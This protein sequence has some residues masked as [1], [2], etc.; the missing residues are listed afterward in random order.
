MNTRNNWLIYSTLRIVF[1]AVP[2][3]V[4]FWI[5]WSVWLAALTAALISLAL[6]LLFLSK[7][8][9]AASES[10]YDW[11]QRTR[12]ADD[13][14]EDEVIDALDEQPQTDTTG[15]ITAA[16]ASEQE[17]SVDRVV[18]GGGAM[19]LA[20]AWQLASRGQHVLLLER[21]APGHAEGASHGETRNMNNAYAE[22][23]FLDLYDEA[24]GLFREL[25]SASN[26]QLL[27]L[28]GLV[29]HGDPVKV[30]ATHEALIA[31]N[32]DTQL[33]SPADAEQRWPGMK[34]DGLVLFNREAGRVH[35]ASTLR[36][37]ASQ[38]TEHGADIRWEHR[39]TNIEV[40]S[41]DSV[42]VTAQ[43]A[44]GST[45]TVLAAGAVVTAGAW[46]EELLRELPGLDVLPTLRVTEE[47]PAHFA[48]VPELSAET[49][50]E[51]PSFNHVFADES[52]TE[53]TAN[54]YGMLTP[55]EGIKVG[56]HLVGREVHPD[57]RPHAVS[58]EAQ[59]ALL[60]YVREWMPG[61]DADTAEW[62][63]CTY[64]TTPSQR[65]VLDRVGPITIGAGFSGQ[66]F[67]FTPAVGRVL[68]DASLGTAQPAEA[69][70]LAAHA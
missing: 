1:F 52:Y 36:V 28:C 21:F 63:S 53:H 41:E 33:L 51:W 60:S 13:I 15:T 68:A 62:V 12:T 49:V 19:G 7:R 9:D 25:E 24:L 20:T 38:A 55:G 47:H 18:V 42:R 37:L 30:H 69:W 5:G 26:E 32:A 59:Q 29:T 17:I 16:P 31:R 2:F 48:P 8:R 70:R 64:T 45:L 50:T 61:L 40:L 54:I 43:T 44:D 6:S 67:K 3:A 34:F 14:L 4:L 46:S 56:Y 65:F 22:T 27:S 35:A 58:D 66:G 57:Q 11:R 23:H 39:V 10:I